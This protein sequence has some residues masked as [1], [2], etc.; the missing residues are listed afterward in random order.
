[1]QNLSYIILLLMFSM[2]VLA[3][4]SPHG[5][6]FDLDCS[7]CHTT[8]NWEIGDK[9]EF[10]HKTTKFDLI[11]QH[12]DVNCSS[13]HIDLSFKNVSEKCENCHKDIHEN[14]VGFDCAR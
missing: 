4:T 3:Q 8:K 1:M 2:N 7:L 13:C 9:I 12:V 10:D 6:E 11:G 14:S 5:E